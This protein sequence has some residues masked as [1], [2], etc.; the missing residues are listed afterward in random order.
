MFQ[1]GKLILFIIGFAFANLALLGHVRAEGPGDTV[2]GGIDPS[3]IFY[4]TG[5]GNLTTT[6]NNDSAFGYNPLHNNTSGSFNTATGSYALYNNTGGNNN[7]ATGASALINN[8]TG[9]HNT[10]IGNYALSHNTTATGNTAIGYLAMSNNTTGDGNTASGSST[11][12]FNTTGTNNTA[13]GSEALFSNTTGSGNTANGFDA[14]VSNGTGNNNTANG[15]EALLSN[16]NG[17]NNTSNGVDSLLNNI[18]GSGNSANGFSA[19]LSNST[20]NFNLANGAGALVY[21]TTGNSNVAEGVNALFR[22][23]TGAGN[24]GI[25]TGA[26]SNLTT[27]NANIDIGNP[28]VAGEAK[29][30]R[31]GT[32]GTQTNTYIAGISGIT[33]AAGAGVMID[34]NGHLGTLVSSKRFKE[35]I[36]PMAKASEAILSL[37]PVTFRYKK[38]FDPKGIAQFGLVAEEVEKVNPDLVARDET[39][40]AYTVRYEAVN[41]MLLNEFLKE[42]RKVEQL[43]STVAQQRNDFAT[44]IAQQ[45]K[46][47]TLLSDVLKAQASQIEKVNEKLAL[48]EEAETN[49]LAAIR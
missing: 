16:D 30:I 14:L 9:N 1:S 5:A 20:G 4:G 22:N 25:G 24:I 19:L 15:W 8:T 49:R 46:E 10:A 45:Q 28:G 35:E 48:Q 40:K 33:V 38:E 39:G 12:Y 44:K 17:N 11:L 2:Y 21:N 3:D 26:G 31:I 42:H 29:T 36:Q 37:K 23:S 47:I 32:Q 18:S 41:A 43:Q 27:G 6:G 13:S 34:S 7:T